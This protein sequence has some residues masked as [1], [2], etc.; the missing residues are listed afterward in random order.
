MNEEQ[1]A[2]RGWTVA[3]IEVVSYA[4]SDRQGKAFVASNAVMAVVN[5]SA[6]GPGNGPA[7]QR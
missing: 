1:Q 2:P 6:V 3:I 4:S 5:V 7:D